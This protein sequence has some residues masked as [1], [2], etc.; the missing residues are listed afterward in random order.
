MLCA[1]LVVVLPVTLVG[2][3]LVAAEKD[4]F[5]ANPPSAH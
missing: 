4:D 1:R 2:A 3:V 5:G